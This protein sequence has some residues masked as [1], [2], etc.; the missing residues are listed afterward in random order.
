[1]KVVDLVDIEKSYLIG[2][3]EICRSEG[4]QPRNRSGRVHSAHGSVRQR[5]INAHEYSGLPGQADTREVFASW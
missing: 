3:S 2:D 4:H 5:Q 1:M